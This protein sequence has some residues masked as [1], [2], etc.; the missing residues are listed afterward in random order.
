T[1]PSP[2]ASVPLRGNA[3]APPL[4][5]GDRGQRGSRGG[6]FHR[7]GELQGLSSGGLRSVEAVEARSR[8]RLPL[9]PTAEGCALPVMPCPGRGGADRFE[10]ELRDVPR[11]RT[12]FRQLERDERR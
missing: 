9:A 8:P 6:G 1:C 5:R 4:F 10:R 7:A 11:R 12:I 3:A 2:R